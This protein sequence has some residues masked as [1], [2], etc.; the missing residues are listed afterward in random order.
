MFFLFISGFRKT[1]THPT[2]LNDDYPEEYK[3]S[4][5][6]QDTEETLISELFRGVPRGTANNCG[7]EQK[8]NFSRRNT[9]NN[10][11]FA[12]LQSCLPYIWVLRKQK[13]ADLN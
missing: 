13:I 1:G 9:Y 10:L 4:Q 7:G 11:Y 8:S 12:L 3:A 2:I 5:Q 6:M